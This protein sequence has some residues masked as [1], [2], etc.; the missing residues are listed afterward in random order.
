MDD[1]SKCYMVV[2]GHTPYLEQVNYFDTFEEAREWA[3]GVMD[4]YA[5]IE[6]SYGWPG[7]WKD[8]ARKQRQGS[9]TYIR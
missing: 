7:H 4:E 9:R 6:I 1:K 5:D 8:V 2:C 3:E